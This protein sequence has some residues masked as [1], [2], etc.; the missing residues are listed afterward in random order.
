MRDRILTSLRWATSAQALAGYMAL[1][2]SRTFGPLFMLI[3][4]LVL[5]LA[6]LGERLDA[7][8]PAYRTFF[9]AVTILYLCFI[10]LS[11][12]SFGALAAVVALAI[13]IQIN[14]LVHKNDNRFYYY[15][16]LMSFFL[17]LAACVESP[18]P[19]I[20]L[21]LV[22]FLISSIWAFI[23]L[24]LH[25]DSQETAGRAEADIVRI[26]GAPILDD[27]RRLLDLGIAGSV[28]CVSLL[29]IFLTAGIFLVTPRIEAGLLGRGNNIMP[30]TG[31]SDEVDLTGGG[32]I[33]AD[34]T[35]VMHVELPGLPGGK[36]R[37]PYS[38]YWRTAT[39][40]RYDQSRWVRRGLSASHE[41]D[42]PDYIGNNRDQRAAE[43]ARE[44]REGGQLIHQLIY[45]DS[46]P[47]EGV[48][49]LDLV[50]RMRIS[51]NASNRRSTRILWDEDRD[52]SVRLIS[53]EGARRLTYE[54]WSEVGERG[55]A[56]ELRAAP[57]NYDELLS[58]ADH[59]LL[60][61]HDLTQPV[62]D[63]AA[64]LTETAGNAYDKAMILTNYL[65]GP[66]FLY[67]LDMPVLPDQH[68]IDMFITEYQ[69][70]HCELFASALALM[71]RSQGIPTRV[72]LG[73]R[74]GEWEE[75]DS[76]YTVRASMAHLWVEVLFPGYGWVVFDPSPIDQDPNRTISY[77]TRLISGTALKM[78]MFWY[79]E[80]IGFDRGLQLDRLRSISLGL[81]GA[82]TG[83]EP[84]TG[85]TGGASGKGAISY[86]TIFIGTLGLVL[87]IAPFLYRRTGSRRALNH[88]WLL[89]PDQARAVKLFRQ[90]RRALHRLGGDSRGMTAE[91]VLATVMATPQVDPATM[92]EAIE[93]YNQAR[94]GAYPLPRERYTALMRAVRRVKPEPA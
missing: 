60:T 64:T 67:T 38:L 24:R 68:A 4:L 11:F 12:I 6:P 49:A 10:P 93:A 47:N 84:R 51:G 59:D 8:Y 37:D 28:L 89:T 76:S 56:E 42:I 52:F 25:I 55:T 20:G 18:E 81:F 15:V 57:T 74:G 86:R 78:K 30:V 88:H 71:L 2:S 45:L 79:Q 91:E 13:Y 9:K 94:F 72:V 85:A 33:T 39:L 90:I 48:P 87:I 22:F 92:I 21:V 43:V 80:V 19:I 14:L 66:P 50:Q 5:P 70:G 3:P 36:V 26:G 58:V 69:R 23:S 73:Y 41:P 44:P 1:S 32:L 46:V 75:S 35:A 65:S 16:Y 40:P 7:R 62:V 63:L 77:F 54:A 17:L 82:I 31:L 34:Q 29:G 61:A 27:S 53:A 83:M